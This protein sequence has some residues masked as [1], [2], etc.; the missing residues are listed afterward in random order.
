MHANLEKR[1]IRLAV[2]QSTYTIAQ[3]SFADR[4]SLLFDALAAEL[5]WSR[6]RLAGYVG[7]GPV[8]KGGNAIMNGDAESSPE[9][10][11]VLLDLYLKHC[12]KKKD[13]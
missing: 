7:F 3:Q 1:F 13:A 10:V 8:P 5:G 12:E 11:Q 2:A 4:Y 9:D 6:A